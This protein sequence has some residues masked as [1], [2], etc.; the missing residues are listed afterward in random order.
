MTM[1][2]DRPSTCW[3]R[4]R[5]FWI[6][7]SEQMR[8]DRKVGVRVGKKEGVAEM[9]GEA[10]EDTADEAQ[11]EVDS[12]L[13]WDPTKFELEAFLYTRSSRFVHTINT[14]GHHDKVYIS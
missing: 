2:R 8:T 13:V 7:S 6:R 12:I 1:I 9:R 4:T 3:S 5:E 14:Y 10:E 11:E